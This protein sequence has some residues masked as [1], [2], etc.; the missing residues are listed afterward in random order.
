MADMSFIEDQLYVFLLISSV[1]LIVRSAG[2]RS[3]VDNHA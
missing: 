2:G 1:K 3:E